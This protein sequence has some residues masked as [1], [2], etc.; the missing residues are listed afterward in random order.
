MK[1]PKIKVKCSGL[2]RLQSYDDR[3]DGRLIIAEGLKNVPFA[4]KRV[5]Y[6]NSLGNKRATRG[7]HSHKKLEQVIFCVNG[8][9]RLS[10][11]DGQNQQSFKMSDPSL[12]IRLGPGLWHEMSDFSP[13][14]VILV[15]ASDYHK[16]SDYIRDY[17][18]F[19]QL[20]VK[21]YARPLR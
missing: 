8:S 14:C 9:F 3:P 1:M 16:E 17:K 18:K 6:I 10:L 12:G 7:K 13:D 20:A 5:Y 2:V 15:L 4:I 19:K 21:K 11:D